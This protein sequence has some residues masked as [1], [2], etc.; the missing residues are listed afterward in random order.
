LTTKKS[1]TLGFVI[2]GGAAHGKDI[3][4]RNGN[5]G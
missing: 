1:P 2:D 3:V 4:A 5:G